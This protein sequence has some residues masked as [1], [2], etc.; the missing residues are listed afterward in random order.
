MD[1][2]KKKNP[3]ET[4]SDVHKKFLNPKG[5]GTWEK[6]TGFI[7]WKIEYSIKESFCGI[8]WE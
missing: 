8:P 1:T 5:R 2:Q 4:T 3:W 7:W 6:T